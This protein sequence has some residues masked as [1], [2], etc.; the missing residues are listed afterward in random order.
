MSTV[1]E[2]TLFLLWSHINN[3]VLCTHNS[4]ISITASDVK[5]NPLKAFI[6]VFIHQSKINY[7]QLLNKYYQLL[8]NTKS[9]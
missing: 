4:K 7:F 3:N 1:F 6:E 9:D 8:K 2:I 5:N